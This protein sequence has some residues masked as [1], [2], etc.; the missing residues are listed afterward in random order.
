MN[1]REEFRR[2]MLCGHGRCFKM[3][4]ENKEIYRDI[5]LYGCL[6]DI[7]FD[8]QCEG[9]RAYFV[10][11]MAN[12]YDDYEYFVEKVME[13]FLS[14][15]INDV[16]HDFWHLACFLDYFYYAWEYDEARKAIDNKYDELYSYIM[17]HRACPKTNA[18]L[19]NFEQLCII[20]MDNIGFYK[21]DYILSDIGRY[22]IKRR[23]TADNELKS[24]FLW[25]YHCLEDH[26]NETPSDYN[27]LEEY[28][29]ECAEGT[30]RT[31]TGIRHFMRVMLT[32]DEETHETFEKP[33][34]AD[35]YIEKAENKKLTVRDKYIFSHAEREEKIKLTNEIL[36]EPDENKKAVLLGAFNC[37]DNIWQSDP[38]PLIKYAHSKNESLKYASINAL[39]H[40][41]AENVHDF[42][43]ELIDS[44]EN[45]AA[46][47]ILLNN[48]KET[49]RKL[50][51]DH[52]SELDIDPNNESGWHGTVHDILNVLE[53]GDSYLPDDFVMWIY[54][55]CMCSVCREYAVDELIIR[56]LLT[57]SLLKECCLDCNDEIRQK[58]KKIDIETNSE[59]NYE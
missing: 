21:T 22:F 47:S 33:L 8:A 44:G 12:E 14:P 48:Y 49:D 28:L 23:N 35:K 53:N 40:I 42:A 13:K 1:N 58:A 57:D 25:F 6:N 50:I 46:I 34:T 15:D 10:A 59:E 31:A 3:L 5:V 55:K 45:S 29:R 24:S 9:T 41:R 7:A 43:A 51:W 52:L 30:S 18:V 36:K 17:T 19:D 32:K 26:F 38:E 16:S 2:L 56:D 20:I 39:T 27:S 54:E 37:S 11:E 4:E